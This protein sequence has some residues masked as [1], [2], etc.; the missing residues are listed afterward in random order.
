MKCVYSG[1]S[2]QKFIRPTDMSKCFQLIHTA[3][4]T[5]FP[6][7]TVSMVTIW[8]LWIQIANIKWLLNLFVGREEIHFDSHECAINM[9]RVI[10]EFYF[11]VNRSHIVIKCEWNLSWYGATENTPVFIIVDASVDITLLSSKTCY[12]SWSIVTL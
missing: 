11:T 3:D 10:L 9:G 7:K 5:N 6:T 1:L 12:S 4:I 2:N 8:K